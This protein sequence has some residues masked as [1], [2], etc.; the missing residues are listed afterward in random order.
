MQRPITVPSRRLTPTAL[1]MAR[2]VECEAW[3]GGPEQDRSISAAVGLV[4]PSLRPKQSPSP[5][6]LGAIRSNGRK[7]SLRE[8]AVELEAA[9]HVTSTG[10]RYG[11]A[12]VA[13]M[14]C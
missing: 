8:V 6:N 2:P 7:R 9:G 3:P 5:R 1:G 13:R 4:S 11:A 10:T 14:I 12:A